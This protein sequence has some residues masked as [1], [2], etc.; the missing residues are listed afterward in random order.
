MTPSSVE[1]E[2]LVCQRLVANDHPVL[3]PPDASAN[4]ESGYDSLVTSLQLVRQAAMAVSGRKHHVAMT[5]RQGG[6]PND[7]VK[8]PRA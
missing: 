8:E 3:T 2:N 5:E 7:E 4:P 6:S 1:P